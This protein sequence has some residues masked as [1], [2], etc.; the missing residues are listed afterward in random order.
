V[1]VLPIS[2]KQET[3]AATVLEK[4]KAANIRATLDTSSDKIG[5]KIRTA[6]LQ[7]T[8]V[9][10]VCGAKEAETEQIAVRRHGKGDLGVQPLAA[11]IEELSAEIRERR[12]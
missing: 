5:K 6:E 4:L 12:L 2:E 1:A 7:K 10:F 8:P 9:M 3:Y 11:T